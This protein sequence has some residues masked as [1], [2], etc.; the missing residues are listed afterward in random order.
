MDVSSAEALILLGKRK[1][2]KQTADP[3]GMTTKR[4]KD[5]S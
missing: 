1:K 3:Y 5:R 2:Q 4:R